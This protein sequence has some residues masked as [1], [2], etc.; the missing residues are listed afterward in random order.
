MPVKFALLP[1]IKLFATGVF[2]LIIRR[3]SLTLRRFLTVSQ[4]LGLL[5]LLFNNDDAAVIKKLLECMRVFINP[6]Y[7][8]V[9]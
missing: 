5:Y 8:L 3:V 2:I 9:K 7:F 4:T 6:K 1:T